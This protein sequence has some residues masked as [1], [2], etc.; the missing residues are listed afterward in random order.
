MSR[1]FGELLTQQ[2]PLSPLD[3][4]EV[5]V[6]QACSRRSFGE[7]A[8]ELGLC[9]PE[10]V[11]RAWLA[12]LDEGVRPV[13]LNRVGIDAQ[14]IAAVPPDVAIE[15]GVVPVRLIDGVLVVATT[16]ERLPLAR[17]LLPQRVTCPVRFATADAGDIARAVE[18]CYLPLLAEC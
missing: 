8:L 18:V 6:E 9:T 3:I 7:V 11:W 16:A 5:L 15:L 14:A 17:V 2:L 4:E 12:Q 13:D 10:H 1:R